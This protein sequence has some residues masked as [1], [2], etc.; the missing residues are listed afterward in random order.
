[1]FLP[2]WRLRLWQGPRP[3][4]PTLRPTSDKSVEPISSDE[5]LDLISE[6]N[7]LLHVVAVVMMIE[8]EFVRIT[9][10]EV[11]AHPLRP[12]ELLSDLHQHLSF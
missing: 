4:F 5:L 7:A 9:F 10:F 11:R 3:I 6:L 8:A 2:P 12:W 1:M